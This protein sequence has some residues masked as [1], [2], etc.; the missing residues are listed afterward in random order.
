MLGAESCWPVTGGAAATCACP[1]ATHLL[2]A[3]CAALAPQGSG[4]QQEQQEQQQP[5][6]DFCVQHD[7][8]LGTLTI[9]PAQPAD[10]GPASVLLTRAFAGS[11]QGVPIGDARQY[12]QDSLTQPPR[13]VLLVA[14]LQP[15]GE[16][17]R[18]LR[19]GGAAPPGEARSSAPGYRLPAARQQDY[20]RDARTALHWSQATSTLALAL[21]LPTCHGRLTSQRRPPFRC[22]PLASAAWPGISAVRHRGPVLLPRNTRGLPHAAAS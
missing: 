4:T 16:V 1:A 14:R 13:G 20:K 3:G 6:S 15:A 18:A 11:L 21:P 7:V 9:R 10:V 22:R 5:F 17:V 2:P 8:P 19:W 12:C